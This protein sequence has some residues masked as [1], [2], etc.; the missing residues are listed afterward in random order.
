M[1]WVFNELKRICAWCKKDMG[2]KPGG[3]GI[4]HGICDDCVK[5]I[6][7]EDMY[8][9]SDRHYKGYRIHES[10]HG[11]SIFDKKGAD[12][13]SFKTLSEA[14]EAIDSYPREE[15][16][17]NYLTPS[18]KRRQ[19]ALN[20]EKKWGAL[21]ADGFTCKVCKTSRQTKEQLESHLRSA[22]GWTFEKTKQ[23]SDSW[24]RGEDDGVSDVLK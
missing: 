22:H 17:K 5:K 23:Y 11:F 9:E 14:K 6:E 1:R 18:E 21:N 12:M 7:D 15:D 13:D 24:E 4:T 10:P 3:D 20:G 16:V 2:S 8:N 19:Q